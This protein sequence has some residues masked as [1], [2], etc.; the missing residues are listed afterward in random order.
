MDE[1]SAGWDLECDLSDFRNRNQ[2]GLKK[3]W[4]WATEELPGLRNEQGL[5]DGSTLLK[6]VKEKKLF[7]HLL[8]NNEANF[9]QGDYRNKYS[10]YCHGVC[11]RGETGLHSDYNK[12]QLRICDQEVE[13][14][15]GWEVVGG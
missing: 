11:R 14:G 7:W 2:E 4:L 13:E 5:G 8:K 1:E 12:E 9:I 3:S 15:R 10:D 6:T